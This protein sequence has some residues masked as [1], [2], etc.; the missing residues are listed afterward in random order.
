MF[1]LINIYIAKGGQSFLPEIV[2]KESFNTFEDAK[3][4][5]E[6]QVDEALYSI[7][8]PGDESEEFCMSHVKE[9]NNSTYITVGKTVDWWTIIEV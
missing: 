4:E 3:D 9:E 1:L 7:Y 2:Y 6:G 5:M 8:F